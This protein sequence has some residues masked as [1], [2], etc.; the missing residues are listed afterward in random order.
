MLPLA[1]KVSKWT[2]AE[3]TDAK[4]RQDKQAACAESQL[5]NTLQ[6]VPGVVQLMGHHVIQDGQT[7]TF[8][9]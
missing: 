7:L 2:T 6:K 1:V 9:E 8:M 4:T 5:L 3:G